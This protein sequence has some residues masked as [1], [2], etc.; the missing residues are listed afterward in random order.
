MNEA[1]KLTLDSVRKLAADYAKKYR[2][3]DVIIGLTGNLGAGKT[4]F[5]KAFGAALGIKKIKSPTFIIVSN[6][7]IGKQKLF[8]FDFYRLHR[9][10]QL[11]HL[12]FDEIIQSKNRIMLI[13]WVDKFP[14]IAKK[15]DLIINFKIVDNKTRDVQIH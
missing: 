4:V 5:A 12:G 6:Y 7:V 2:G 3:K 15:C 10:E 8:H 1:Q 13:E 14:E 11:D 9:P